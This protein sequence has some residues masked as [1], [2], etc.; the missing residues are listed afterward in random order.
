MGERG[1]GFWGVGASCES[2][3]VDWVHLRVR[4]YGVLVAIFYGRC[5]RTRF[6]WSLGIEY[7]PLPLKITIKT[8]IKFIIHVHVANGLV[9]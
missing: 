8:S 1:E 4:E 7:C 3:M 9:Y 6:V 5:N 2:L